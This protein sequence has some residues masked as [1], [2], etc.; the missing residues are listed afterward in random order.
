MTSQKTAAKETS[1][2]EEGSIFGNRKLSWEFWES[3][4]KQE[5]SRFL[6]RTR[7]LFPPRQNRLYSIIGVLLISCNHGVISWFYHAC[8]YVAPSST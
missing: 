2:T 4:S 8:Y 1:E 6:D 7:A 3:P 5:V